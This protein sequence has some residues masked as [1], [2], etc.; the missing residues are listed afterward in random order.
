MLFLF[1]KMDL[2]NTQAIAEYYVLDETNKRI[3]RVEFTEIN[4]QK[5]II[6]TFDIFKLLES[7][8]NSDCLVE[9]KLIDLS[10]M[11]KLVLEKPSK[12][13]KYSNPSSIDKLLLHYKLKTKE[14][15]EFFIKIINTDISQITEEQILDILQC[16]HDLYYKLDSDLKEK[17]EHQRFYEIELPM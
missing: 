11:Y 14:D 2:F 3:K 13:S 12:E 17:I 16:E 10:Q 8:R 4:R 15:I 7:L 6:V 5:N 1:T 9:A